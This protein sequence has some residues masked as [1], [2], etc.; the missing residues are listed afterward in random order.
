VWL[1]EYRK[2]LFPEPNP[3]DA[4]KLKE[5]MR[6]TYQQRRLRKNEIIF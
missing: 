3:K 5:F 1:A 6:V 4:F 2:S